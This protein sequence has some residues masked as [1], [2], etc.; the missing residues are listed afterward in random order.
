MAFDWSVIIKAALSFIQQKEAEKSAPPTPA[1]APLAP[2]EMNTLDWS[3]PECMVSKYFSVNNCL[4]LH[5]W[6][7]L[8]TT[9]DGYDPNQLIAL[10]VKLDQVREILGVPMNVHCMFRSKEYNIEQK[11]LLPTGN[12]VHAMSLAV[13]FDAGPSLTT[14]EVKAKL[15]PMLEELGIRMENNGARSSWIH[16]DIHPV[17]HN[18]FFKP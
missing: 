15:L 3:N 5:S 12:D 8:A 13:D 14:D 11:I 1:Q 10:C 2:P 17:I 7:R 18:R 9:E 6:N 16:V 4:L